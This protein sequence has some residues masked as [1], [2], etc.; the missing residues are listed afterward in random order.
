MLRLLASDY[1]AH[2]TPQAQM[3]VLRGISLFIYL[4]YCGDQP[5]RYVGE[6]NPGP[7]SS[8]SVWAKLEATLALI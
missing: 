1:H 4:A 8:E 6:P 7:P 2:S 5:G 3:E